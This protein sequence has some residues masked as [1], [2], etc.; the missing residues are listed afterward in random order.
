MALALQM[1]STLFEASDVTFN[2]TQARLEPTDSALLPLD[3]ATAY[4]DD[5]LV[6]LGLYTE[7][8]TSFI[9]SVFPAPFGDIA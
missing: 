9:A 1:C 2:P 6:A 8:K 7:A 3:K 4:I 5:A